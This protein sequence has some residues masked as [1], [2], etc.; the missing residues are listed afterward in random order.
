MANVETR[1]HVAVPGT[2]F[3]GDQPLVAVMRG[4]LVGSMHRG[5]IA[6]ATPSGDLIAS[7]G[8]A[9]Q[10]VFLRSGAKP[11]QVM[12][13]LLA[14]AVERFELTEAELAVLC[15]SHNAQTEH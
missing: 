11:F 10:P 8:D 5:T 1:V 9:T 15:A 2:A 4:G 3:A 13:A 7:L 14:G 6:V 12:P